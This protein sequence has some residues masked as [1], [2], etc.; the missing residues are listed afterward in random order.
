MGQ[1]TAI[2]YTRGAP[3]M[4]ILD[5]LAR[6]FGAHPLW[7]GERDG[8]TIARFRPIQ[9]VRLEP[10]T[11]V[12]VTAGMSDRAMSIPSEDERARVEIAWA[13]PGGWERAWSAASEDELFV[14][15]ALGLLA[16][17][18]FRSDTWLGVGHTIPG[19]RPV[20][21]GTRLCGFAM[22]GPAFLLSDAPL[23][24]EGHAVH[25]LTCAPV[26]ELELSFAYARDTRALFD[27]LVTMLGA[28]HQDWGFLSLPQRPD[29][30]GGDTVFIRAV[31][32]HFAVIIASWPEQNEVAIYQA[33]T[34]WAREEQGFSEDAVCVDI[35]R[36][37]DSPARMEAYSY[38]PFEVPGG[39]VEAWAA[40][41]VQSLHA[42]VEPLGATGIRFENIAEAEADGGGE[43]EGEE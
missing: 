21:A 9:G 6:R 8:V 37:A 10:G 31:A 27:R 35:L 38:G 22:F 24:N 25:I 41:L 30:V 23:D 42:R 13:V 34:E 39:E 26:Y 33:L 16:A 14:V 4:S 5:Q 15:E 36:G 40:A 28:L 12:F 3:S 43:G 1:R 32:V 7:T 11:E 18:P 29:T 20:A 17:Y 2:P 19:G